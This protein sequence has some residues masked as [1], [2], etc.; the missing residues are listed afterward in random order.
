M[1][2]EKDKALTHDKN[3]ELK[4]GME[5]VHKVEY[6]LLHSEGEENDIIIDYIILHIRLQK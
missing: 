6:Y 2:K 4:D 5:S 3:I 1:R